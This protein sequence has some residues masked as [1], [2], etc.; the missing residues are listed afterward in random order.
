MKTKK[1]HLIIREDKKLEYL[2][3]KDDRLDLNESTIEA[4]IGQV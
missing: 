4:K 3:R 1:V 2:I